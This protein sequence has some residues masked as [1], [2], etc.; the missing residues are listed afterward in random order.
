MDVPVAHLLL[1]GYPAKD[2]KRKT[3]IRPSGQALETNSLDFHK[4]EKHVGQHRK[5]KIQDIV[6]KQQQIARLNTEELITVPLDQE[7]M[8]PQVLLPLR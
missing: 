1:I 4:R 2:G 6:L 8:L 3:E 5:R 7:K